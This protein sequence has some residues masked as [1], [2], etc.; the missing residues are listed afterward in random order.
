M[1]W[2]RSITFKII[3]SVAVTTAVI[4]VA[5]GYLYLTTQI[6][7][8]EETNL[9]SA[10]QLSETIKKSI[11][12]DMLDN[13]KENAYRIMETIGEQEGIEKVRIYSSTGRILFSSNPAEKGTV[14]DKRA[15]ACA[16]C[17]SEAKPIRALGIS[18]RSRVF[19]GP[20]GYRVLGMI[21]PMYNEPGCS[22]TACHV[23]PESQNVLGVIDVILSLA[24]VDKAITAARNRTIHLSLLTI[25]ALSVI[26]VVSLMKLV[27]RRIK[28]LVVGMRK[29]ASGDLDYSIPASTRDEMGYLA[30]SFN[31]MTTNLRKANEEILDLVRTLENRVDERTKELR[32]TQSQLV[33]VEKLAALGRIAATVAHEINNPLTGVFTY[34]KLMERRID[35]GKASPEAI[36]KFRE[37]LSTMS[38][39]VQRTSA[40]VL[41]LLDF[42]RPKEPSR[43]QIVLNDLIEESLSIVRNKISSH[44]ITVEEDFHPMPQISADPSQIKQVFINLIVNACEAMLRGGVLTIRSGLDQATCT[45]SVAFSDTGPGIPSENIQRIFDP[46]FTTK[47]KGT[48]LGLSVAHGI[49]SRH[50]G[51]ID[52]VTGVDGTIMTVVLPMSAVD[53]PGPVQERNRP[54]GLPAGV[55][56]AHD[57]ADRMT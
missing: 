4:S 45:Q 49:I 27:T 22:N 33:H 28:A 19:Q 13:R 57:Q 10:S 53:V 17:H 21:N 43:K 31:R 7:Q 16:A 56:S 30:L 2:I 36:A 11:R 9:R 12:L 41:N 55:Q 6:R 23:H 29:V 24:D 1:R 44:G 26:I 52:V 47:E 42:T 8:I 35:A 54:P 40:I 15:E 5:T 32:E 50:G 20:G 51:R 46:F 34:I 14:V 18:D 3:L 25:L 37:Y 39:E 38:R 48:G